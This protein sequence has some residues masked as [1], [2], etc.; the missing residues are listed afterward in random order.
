[1]SAGYLSSL[2]PA[3]LIGLEDSARKDRYLYDPTLWIH[4]HLGLNLT[5][6]QSEVADAVVSGPTKSI[7]VRAGHGTG[8]SAIAS[9]LG[10][11]WIDVHPLGQAFV[12]STAPSAAQVGGILFREMKRWHKLSGERHDEYLRLKAN[13]QDTGTL[14]DHRLPGS[15]N[16]ANEWKLDD[17]TL[18]AVGRRP[19]DSK[20]E[21]SFQGLHSPFLLSIG[22]EAGGLREGM[23]DALANI[24]TGVNCRRLLIGN[25]S[26]PR[27]RFGTIFKDPSGA[28]SLYHMSVLQNPNFHGGGK[29]SCA[30]HV[31]QPYGLGMSKLALES[32]SGPEYVEEKRLEYGEDSARYKVRVLGDFA[33]DAGNNLFTD[34][35]IGKARDAEVF[36]DYESSETKTVLG[37][38][39]A[40]SKYGDTSFVYRFTT[41]SMRTLDNLTGKPMHVTDTPGGELRLVDSYRGLPLVDR[42]ETDGTLTIGQA[43][44]IHQHAIALNVSEVRIDSGGLGIGLVDGI[45]FLCRGKYRVVEMQG[46]AGSPDGRQWINNRA[47]QFAQMAKRFGNGLVDIDTGDST[48]IEQLED[49]LIE[50]VD[51]HNAM[52]VESKISMKKRGVSSP[53]AADAAWYACADLR[54]LDGPK[55]GQLLIKSPDQIMQELMLSGYTDPYPF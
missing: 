44:L 29:C 51:P 7:A 20:D 16:G 8:K 1:M 50:Y 46:G 55:D 12:A 36:I 39:V 13:G 11:F 42:Y 34:Y 23:I 32:L 49:I 9:L 28:W 53:D 38:D 18:V 31:G 45:M 14:P 25:P 3:V 35:E 47:Y 26:N 33:Y 15:I 43:T 5:L 24:S 21:D 48:L 40:R 6:K 10:V 41:G 27:S 2:L 19:P 52:K 17:G 37:V 30:E 22:D 54:H 4:D